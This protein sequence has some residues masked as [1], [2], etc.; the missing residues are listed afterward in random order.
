MR[1]KFLVLVLTI[2]LLFLTGFF[3]LLSKT[4]SINNSNTALNKNLGKAINKVSSVDAGKDNSNISINSDSSLANNNE[5]ASN[6]GADI[7]AAKKPILTPN[8]VVNYCSTAKN[9]SRSECLVQFFKD[10]ATKTSFS[11]SNATLA[12][13]ATKTNGFDGLCHSIG[14]AYGAWAFDHYGKAVL[15]QVTDICGF[16][17]GHGML[18]AAGEKLSKTD[19]TM[20]FADFCKYSTIIS[21]CVHGYGHALWQAKYSVFEI[22]AVCGKVA[23]RLMVLYPKTNVSLLSLCTE[24][25]MMED[26]IN[27][28]KFWGVEQSIA[29]SISLCKGLATYAYYGCSDIAVSNWA[30]SPKLYHSDFTT[31]KKRLSDFRDYCLTL[32]QLPQGI[33]YG[34]LGYTTVSIINGPV[35]G[36]K[37]APILVNVCSGSQWRYCIGAYVNGVLGLLDNNKVFLTNLCLKL[38]K[39][40]REV[41]NQAT[42]PNI[43]K[44]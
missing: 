4:T 23:D 24:G 12:N 11:K 13:L 6:G 26:L 20:N 2:S 42:L 40:W 36:E 29:S 43:N 28:P 25:W 14:H 34:H 7:A 31:A 37:V 41:C 44:I 16:S 21:D 9:I 35:L 30:I 10:Y 19:F 32:A 3:L 8:N 33:C 1:K 39:D 18:Q 38:P 22:G 15:T 17:V 5:S 27:N